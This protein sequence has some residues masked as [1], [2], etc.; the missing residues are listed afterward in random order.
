MAQ[1]SGTSAQLNIGSFP[2]L[3]IPEVT[4]EERVHEDQH[5]LLWQVRGGTTLRLSGPELPLG[6]E[7]HALPSGHVLWL[8]AGV[9]HRLQVHEDSVMLPMF[10]S[11]E[12]TVTTL[13]GTQML[14]VDRQ[15]RTLFLAQIQ[16]QYSIIKP[17]ANIA[18]QILSRLEQQPLLTGALPTP[19]SEAAG[20]IAECLRF[21]PG[22]DRSTAA[23]AASVHTSERTI[24]RVFLAETG[25]TLRQWRIANRMEAAGTLLRSMTTLPAVAHRVGYTNI[26][27][28]GRV[29]KRH[30]GMTP[31]AYIARFRNQG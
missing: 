5:L 6:G 27:S 3:H 18:R 21:N 1:A 14:P 17:A 10:F 15:L 20:E 29:F 11:A 19:V 8:P 28:F 30:F 4:V 24:E 2:R 23:L 13:G 26:S 31:T 7:E 12:A 25:M 22:D 9:R 16:T